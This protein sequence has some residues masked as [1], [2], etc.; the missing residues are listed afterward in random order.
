MPVRTP[1]ALAKALESF[2][3][4]SALTARMGKE[5]RFIAE[6]ELD[7]RKAADLI[8]SVMKLVS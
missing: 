8:L 1:E 4:D 7:A 6:T 3:E 2:L 5:G